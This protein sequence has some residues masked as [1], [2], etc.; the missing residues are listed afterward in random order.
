MMTASKPKISR[1]GP[2]RRIEIGAHR[3]E[4]AG[5]RNHRQRQRHRQRENMAVVEA[6][7][8]RHRRVVGGGAEGAAERGAIEHELQG[9]DHGDGDGELQER[10]HAD[11]DA[12]GEPDGRHFKRAGLQFD[13]VSG[14]HRKQSVLDDD[15]EAEG[16]Q[17]R[18]Q[19]IFAE[20]AVEH[21]PLQRIAEQRHHRH[22]HD[23]RS[24][25]PDAEHFCRHQR[26]VSRQHDQIAMGD[27]DEPHHA[28]DQRQSGG[29]HGVEPAD[30]DALKDD[31][32]PFHHGTP[33][34]SALVREGKNHT[35]KYAAAICSRERSFDAPA[36]ATRP[37]CRQ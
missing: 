5:N 20:R 25:R 17:E 33:S 35:P 3:E 7:Q 32:D 1:A 34:P 31:V 16:H 2:V 14:E 27:I 29:E 19:Q 11:I 13:A 30:Q 8:L 24:Q 23:Q 15:R 10:Q 18:R 6:H 12:V 4:H 28:E 9:A 21:E 26:D 37:S 36:S 22:H